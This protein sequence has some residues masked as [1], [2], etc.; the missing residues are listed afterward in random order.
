MHEREAVAILGGTVRYD[1]T[2]WLSTSK[3]DADVIKS[4]RDENAAFKLEALK[5]KA[6]EEDALNQLQEIQD[7][8]DKK[9]QFLIEYVEESRNMAIAS[10]KQMIIHARNGCVLAEYN[11]DTL[12]QVRP[13]EPHEYDSPRA[14]R[15]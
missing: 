9:T 15:A 7:S 13:K 6:A 3:S 1:V 4:L 14:P 5:S 11:P 10:I 8:D 12:I 2:S